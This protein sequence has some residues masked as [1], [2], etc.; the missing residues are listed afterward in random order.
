MT[1]LIHGSGGVV[2]VDSKSGVPA[3]SRLAVDR[4]NTNLRF[5][6]LP[7]SGGA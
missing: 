1:G 2:M 3:F 4:N 5:M 7:V 6:A